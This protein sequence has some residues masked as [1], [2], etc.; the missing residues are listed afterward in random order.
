MP[1]ALVAAR[2]GAEALAAAI[3]RGL[4][5]GPALRERCR[6]LIVERCAW[7]TVGAAWDALLHEAAR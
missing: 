3:D 5:L 2:P 1:I 4:A 6:E 7:N